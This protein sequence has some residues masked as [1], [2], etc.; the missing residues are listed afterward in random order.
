M[1]RVTRA[2]C[3]RSQLPTALAFIGFWSAVVSFDGVALPVTAA[4]PHVVRVGT[5]LNAGRHTADVQACFAIAN[6]RHWAKSRYVPAATIPA[7]KKLYQR[8]IEAT[9]RQIDALVYELYG[10]TKEEIRV[11]EGLE[12]E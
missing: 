10:L 7:D 5:I 2:N 4:E 12:H 3:R 1:A 8:Q 6:L 9:D 11:V